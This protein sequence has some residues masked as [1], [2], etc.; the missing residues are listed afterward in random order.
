M[1]IFTEETK[2]IEFNETIPITH[3][4][5]DIIN[6]DMF[7]FK[8]Y[9]RWFKYKNEYYFY[10]YLKQLEILC[11]LVGEKV[12]KEIFDL[13]VV[14]FC[15]A[16]SE[17]TIFIASKNKREQGKEYFYA[18]HEYFPL[19][20]PCDNFLFLKQL[21][22]NLENANTLI[23]DLIRLI[24]F[25]IYTNL[26]DLNFYNLLFQKESDGFSYS[27]IYDL[28]FSFKSFKI[29]KYYYESSIC[30]FT[31]P[32]DACTSFLENYPLFGTMLKC[33]LDIDIAKIMQEIKEEYKLN[34]FNYYI[35]YFKRQ[36]EIKKDFILNLSL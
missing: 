10:K 33:I 17:N 24:A 6:I 15:F 4:N 9:P 12:A 1:N 30:R 36:D 5:A 31:I 23:N 20:N 32:S 18:S 7:N 28:D 22:K 8:K 34:I 11:Y 13:P 26:E 3:E 14:N 16:R 29:D 25:H 27:F 19:C 2:I 35:E 21:F